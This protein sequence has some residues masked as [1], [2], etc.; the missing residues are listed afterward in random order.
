[1]YKFFLIFFFIF[2]HLIFQVDASNCK[3]I[4]K[5]NECNSA[6]KSYIWRDNSF[7]EKWTSIRSI[8]DFICLQDTPENRVFQIALDENFRKIDDEM[9]KYLD[10]LTNSKNFYFWKEAQ[11]S[12]FDW[13]NHIW[14]KSRYFKNLYNAACVQSIVDAASCIENDLYTVPE[15]RP[16][17]SVESAK[18]YL[19]WSSWDCYNLA[20]VKVEIFNN[21]AFNVLQLNKVQVFR[22][23]K[24]L[25]EQE[26]RTK[27]SKLSDLMMI[28]LS[29]L[30][31][32][33]MKWP[34]KIKNAY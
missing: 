20:N 31:R 34:S 16:S 1:M 32:I 14:E 19:N 28:N 21:V 4:W 10:S 7:I 8:E 27:Y 30:E 2:F 23:Q 25:Y 5:I 24:K 3:F 6:L 29:Y 15:E 18:Q 22:D 9:D 13:I 26:Q 17:I 12:Y 33:W 11:F